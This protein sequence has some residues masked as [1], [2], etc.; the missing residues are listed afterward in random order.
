M[1]T[2]TKPAW[3]VHKKSIMNTELV[4]VLDLD[5][6]EEALKAVELCNMCRWFKVGSQLFTRCG[7]EVIRE[8]QA[9]G[10]SVFL[11]LKFHD[12]P[13]T[14]A[15]S[16]RAAA[17]LGVKLFTLHAS[18]GRNMIEAAR[19]AVEYT[20]TR[21]LAVTVLTS[22]TD[23]MLRDDVGIPESSTMAVKRLAQVAIEAGAHG[24]VCSPLEIDIV[25]QAIGPDHLVVTPGIR[26]L[27][28]GKDDQAR[29]LTPRQA[30]QAG[31]DMIVVGRPILKHDRPEEA[32][33][34]ILEELTP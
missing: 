8:I 16:A 2:V 5:T 12:I 3:S 32:I 19:R 28:A 33:R 27:W 4:V 14:V 26:P 15:L 25:R 22:L 10:K 34:L 21:I 24:V 11:D 29:V 31:A 9:R 7:P 18:G 23:A 13:N 30:A 17:D 1:V 20:D 6:A